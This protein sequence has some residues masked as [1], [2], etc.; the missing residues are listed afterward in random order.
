MTEVVRLGELA[1]PLDLVGGLVVGVVT[2]NG[3]AHA[4]TVELDSLLVGLL[5][6]D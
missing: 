1:E 6:L 2:S 5:R 4:A 3:I